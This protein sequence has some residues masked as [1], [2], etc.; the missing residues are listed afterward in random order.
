MLTQIPAAAWYHGKQTRVVTFH[1]KVSIIIQG[2]HGGRRREFCSC[3]LTF[4]TRTFCFEIESHMRIMNE[5]D[6]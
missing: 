6:Y 2:M 1:F 4:R 3:S 5:N